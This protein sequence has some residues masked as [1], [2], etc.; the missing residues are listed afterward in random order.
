VSLDLDDLWTYLRT[1]GDPVWQHRPSY[2]PVFL[3]RALDFLEGLSLRITFFLVGEDTER[4][5]NRHRLREITPA[6]HEVGNHSFSHEPWLH[7]SSRATLQDEVSRAE[8]SITE[9]C[10]QRPVGFRGPGFSWSRELVNVLLERGYL[11]DASSLPTFVAPLARM[12]FLA[13]SRMSPDEQRRRQGLFGGFRD[14]FRPLK[15]Y[16]W[17]M[18]E[19]R[20]LEIPVTTM[21]VLRTPFHMSYLLYLGRRSER[22]MIGYLRA[23]LKA[24]QVTGVQP[25]FLLHPLDFL[26][27]DEA[28]GLSFFPGMDLPASRKLALVARAMRVLGE[29]YRLVT[30]AEHARAAEG[31]E[32][33]VA[34]AYV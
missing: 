32:H 17:Q 16:R 11:Y 24:C 1:R 33:R 22:L 20:L 14:G 2:L 19:R 31:L 18:G 9:V 30:M 6:G 29:S 12:Y 5:A 26:D 34:E 8:E 28:P 27:R 25:S 23:A 4:P 15:P 10:G 13:G 7:L 21:P 3:P